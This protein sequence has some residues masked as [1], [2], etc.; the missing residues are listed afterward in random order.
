MV[1]F[2]FLDFNIGAFMNCG[3]QQYMGQKSD[4]KGQGISTEN[5]TREA[6]DCQSIY[7]VIICAPLLVRAVL[8][9]LIRW[10]RNFNFKRKSNARFPKE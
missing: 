10:T 6:E 4:M 7:F 2:W 9:F 5:Y 3:G 1:C 8:S